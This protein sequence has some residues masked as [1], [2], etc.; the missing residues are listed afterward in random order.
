VVTPDWERKPFRDLALLRDSQS[1]VAT[2][3]LSS[4][5]QEFVHGV[6]RGP[7]RLGWRAVP[8]FM[9]KA[10][11]AS[12][13]FVAIGLLV[14]GLAALNI[15]TFTIDDRTVSGPEF[16]TRVYPGGLPLLAL[17]GALSYGYWTEKLWARPLPLI[18]ALLVD[19]VLLWQVRGN[20]LARGDAPGLMAW[21]V[22][23]VVIA[24]WYCYYKQSVIAYYRA[25]ERA[26]ADAASQ[27][28][29]ATRA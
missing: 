3:V 22:L 29:P 12:A 8:W 28:T 24:L 18:L 25:L 26:H 6:R 9:R 21:A 4:T 27:G 5:F 14:A 16:L 19:V 23:Y 15:G 1:G 2:A 7:E 10:G 11:V 13:L 20:G 17:L